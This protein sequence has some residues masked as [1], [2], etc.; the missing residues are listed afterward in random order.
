[1]V[2]RFF[3]S[4]RTGFYVAVTREGEVG[5]GD[6]MKLVHS[7]PNAVPVSEIMRLY[8]AKSFSDADVGS[9]RRALQVDALPEGWKEYFREML[10]Q[11]TT[12]G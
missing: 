8:T 1:M 9:I 4:R 3:A 2:K 12:L 5:A 11:G 10:A 7:D 6:E